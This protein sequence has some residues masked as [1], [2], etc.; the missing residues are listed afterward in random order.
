MSW[1]PDASDAALL[2]VLGTRLWARVTKSDGC[3][4]F[5]GPANNCGYGVIYHRTNERY[6]AH[7]VS[8]ILAFGAIPEGMYV[9]HHCDNR[10]CVR[11]DHFFLGTHADNQRD[12]VSKGRHRH[13]R[14]SPKDG[15]TEICSRG[16]AY[17][18]ENTTQRK[19]GRRR[20]RTCENNRHRGRYWRRKHAKQQQQQ[21]AA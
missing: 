9:C 8:Y 19:D 5:R 12:K 15:V 11:P 17:T 4:E 14:I 6:L 2:A 18:P 7:R 1:T 16:H 20:C 13:P 21:A 3:W 10:K